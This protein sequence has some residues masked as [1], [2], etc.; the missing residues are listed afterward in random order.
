M[1]A[2][3]SILT[4]VLLLTLL[5]VGLATRPPV[6]AGSVSQ[7]L[8]ISHIYPLQ[9][10]Y[11]SLSLTTD[12]N[13]YLTGETVKITVTTGA[14]DSHVIITAQLPDGT[15]QSI[16]SFTFN[17][18]RTISW[19]APATTGQIRIDCDVDAPAEVWDYCTRRVCIGPDNIDC[20]WENYPCRRT[21]PITGN[22]FNYITIFG[23]TTSVSG[24]I[25]DTNQ[26]PV[27]GAIL[28]IL[29][30][31]QSTT[32]DNDGY[33]QFTYRLGNNYDIS[34]QIPT[35]TD[36]ITIDAVACEPQPGKTV[37]IQAEQGASDVNFTL[38]RDFYPPDINLSDFTYSAFLSWPSAKDY[39]TWQNIAGITVDGPVQVTRFQY[40]NKGTSP[41][42]FDIGSKVLYLLTTTESGRYLLDIQG[43]PNSHYK[44]GAAAT[45]NGIYLQPVTVS[46][47]IPSNG[48]QRL[49]LT[50][51]PNQVQLETI[52]PSP[53]ILIIV[54]IIVIVLGGLAAAFFLTGGT[55]RWAQVFSR[56][57]LFKKKEKTAKPQPAL[58]KSSVKSTGNRSK[59]SRTIA[60]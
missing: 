46:S 49:V 33:Y 7:P 6:S 35:A 4:A 32:S 26:I 36:T 5:A 40:G 19:T 59:H 47:N 14:I 29:S 1:R 8:G 45:I 44:V 2:G 25:I 24:R 18:M 37:L 55:A 39:S 48:R 60:K 43:A 30:T 51:Q 20:H 50:L 31:G 21:I 12:K 13:A 56:L 41:M 38:K 9:P 42:S 3:S 15:Q 53:V 10:S 11:L 34:N 57:K 16:D 17:Y 27:S 22:T 58:G 54:I 23:R 52:K 28:S